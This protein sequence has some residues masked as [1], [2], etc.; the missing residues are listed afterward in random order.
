MANVHQN[1]WQYYV[2]GS[3][4][5]FSNVSSTYTDAGSY[6]V[7]VK[8]ISSGIRLESLWLCV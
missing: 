2:K 6:L 4:L 1:P 8:G 3:N 7:L 5:V